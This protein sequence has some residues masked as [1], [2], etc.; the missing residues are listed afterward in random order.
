MKLRWKYSPVYQGNS[1]HVL[2]AK[3]LF[4]NFHIQDNKIQFPK[5]LLQPSTITKLQWGVCSPSLLHFFTWNF[6]HKPAPS[7]E[8][9]PPPPEH[10]DCALAPAYSPPSRKNRDASCSP[11]S[12]NIFAPIL[13]S[14]T[15]DCIT[16]TFCFHKKMLFTQKLSYSHWHFLH[17]GHNPG[18]FHRTFREVF[19]TLRM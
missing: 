10:A 15:H 17:E 19:A 2:I 5:E 8:P 9:P 18:V 14:L 13:R 16:A 3:L 11:H 1:F 12:Q 6:P 4:L 7:L